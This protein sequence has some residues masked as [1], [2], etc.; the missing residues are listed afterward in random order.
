[1]VGATCAD[2]LRIALLSLAR[3]PGEVAARSRLLR[4]SIGIAVFALAYRATLAQG[5]HDQARYAVPAPYVLQEDL[6]RARDVQQAAADVPGTR[7][8][9]DS[10]SV[11]GRRRTSPCS[12][13]PRERS[14]QIDGWRCDFSPRSPRSSEADPAAVVDAAERVPVPQTFRFTIA[15]DRIGVALVVHFRA[16]TSRR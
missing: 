5:E 15:G 7:V 3:A 6:T 14:P 1:M 16:A 12:R 4:V 8:L 11:G 9:R 2:L 13:C 10:G